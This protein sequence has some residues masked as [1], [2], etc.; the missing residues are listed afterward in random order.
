MNSLIRPKHMEAGHM[1]FYSTGIFKKHISA[2]ARIAGPKEDGKAYI[3]LARIPYKGEG[4]DLA[5]GKHHWA[6]LGD[7]YDINGF[8]KEVFF[9]KGPVNVQLTWANA[10]EIISLPGIG[11]NDKNVLAV[12]FGY[13]C[14]HGFGI[15]V[16]ANGGCCQIP[17]SYVRHILDGEGRMIWCDQTLLLDS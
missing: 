15:H 16:L 8:L 11:V 12:P 14:E 7:L 13:I 5:S 3:T 4:V 6:E 17:Y 10:R 9:Y 2:T 1:V